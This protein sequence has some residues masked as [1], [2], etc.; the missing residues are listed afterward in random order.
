[1]IEREPHDRATTLDGATFA[2]PD[3]DAADSASPAPDALAAD[4]S[5]V[6]RF[7]PIG[8]FRPTLEFL[9][10]LLIGI[11]VARTF[12][13][14][15]Y[16]VPTGSMA[17]TLL[18]THRDYQCG[19]CLYRFAL[20]TDEDGRGGRP[21]CPNCGLFDPDRLVATEATGDRLLVQ[22]YLFDL[23]DPQRWEAAVFQNPTDPGQA[24]V[25]RIVGL[26]G[27]SIEIRGGEIYINGHIARKNAEQQ[28]AL[29][30][31]VYDHDHTPADL[32]RYPR[33]LFRMDGPRGWFHSGWKTAGP[34]LVREPTPA[35]RDRTDWVHYRHW[36]PDGKNY[37]SIR[38]FIAYNGLDLAGEN[39]V[40][41][42]TV[43]ARMVVGAG[44]DAV[45]VRLSCGGDRFQVSIP[46]RGSTQR[47]EVRRDGRPV[48][49]EPN[50]EAPELLPSEPS[51][52]RPRRL[53]VALVDQRLA[54]TLDGVS[55]FPP[56]DYDDPKVAPA[57]FH[58]P[59]ALGVTGEGWAEFSGLRIYRDVYYTDALATAPQRPFGVGEPFQLGPDEYFV[60]GDNS[61]VSNDS[62]FWPDSPVVWRSL[63][64]GKPF[65][66]HL[67]SQAV[68]LQVFGHEL[69]WIPDPRE[70]RYIR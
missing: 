3:P 14:E 58:S 64:L 65:L 12:A 6:A 63:F 22:K 38:D 61:P 8:T 30:M 21:V 34:R 9:A 28:R 45:R 17:P 70:I 53:E 43:A 33:W 29:R 66:V 44:I 54:V 32:D 24:Y 57:T 25:K 13:A 16:I 56:I 40:D 10:V 67:P 2:H 39:R 36:Q 51:R 69:Y 60:L 62:R 11:L 41:D 55:L 26:P 50:P 27:E 20:G 23:R 4:L 18:G 49:I 68:P 52:P 37:G 48:A 46:V 31:L 7:H 15:A 59:V 35:G 47:L 1:V 19:N 5:E 42:L